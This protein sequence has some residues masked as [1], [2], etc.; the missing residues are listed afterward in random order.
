MTAI[1]GEQTSSIHEYLPL[2]PHASN[3]PAGHLDFG[4]L[5][6]DAF[7]PFDSRSQAEL[8]T[9]A[10]DQPSALE[11]ERALWA[12]A[13]RA[14]ADAADTIVAYVA[15][16]PDRDARIG[17][18]WLLV[19]TL[20]TPAIEHLAR[21]FETDDDPELRDW[22]STLLGDLTGEARSSLYTTVNVDEDRTFDQTVPL[23]I[24]GSVIV[25]VPTIGL[26][27]AVLS[28]LWFEKILGR[29]L[30]ST[31]QRTIATDLV[32]EK[33]VKGMRVDGS[34]YYESFL[35]RG[36]S[37]PLGDRFY[38]HN[39]LSL[40]VRDFYP[41]G[42]VEEGE[43][44]GVPIAAE[45]AALT[46]FGRKGEF[47]F[48]GEGDRAERMRSAEL[49]FVRSVRGRY[50]GW[51]AVNLETVATTGHVPAGSVQLSNPTDPISG[52]MTNAKLFGLFRGKAGDL[53]GDGVID[54]NH[55]HCHG[56]TSGELDLSCGG[57]LPA[58]SE[59]AGHDA[60]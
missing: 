28:P 44:V 49:P 6:R 30:A 56:T 7:L 53:T 35:F 42:T 3:D 2:D 45:R 43:P 41:S 11:R 16:E 52:P 13:D 47:R 48:V 15:N 25:Q 20:G 26:T 36:M 40:M 21:C 19:Q 37:M 54:L 18:L 33:A 27:R 14:G 4:R 10:F 12:L 23:K 17:A 31:N 57:H 55:I 9:A 50:S 59:A 60:R 32:I 58:R 22:S 24:C 5:S 51:A 39:Y 34:T 46:E 1:S 29:V 38:E 8:R